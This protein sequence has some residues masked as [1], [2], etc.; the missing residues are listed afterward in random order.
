MKIVFLGSSDFSVLSLKR[1]IENGHKILAVVCQP[2]K[3]KGR[4]NKV[5]FSSVK[6]LAIENNIPVYQFQKIRAEGVE[7]LKDLQPELL[8]VVSYGQILSQEIIDIGSKGIINIHASLLPK[9]RGASPIITAVLNGE[10]K[11]G[12]TIMRVVKAVDAGNML[13]KAELE[14]DENETGGELADRLSRLGADLL[15][16]AIKKMESNEMV[17]EEQNENQATFTKMI[18]KEDA[19]L[20]FSKSAW[21]LKNQ[22]RAFNPTPIAFF[23]YGEEKIKV[24]ECEVVK[25]T[26]GIPGEI[27]KSSI[28]EGLVIK[29]GENAISIKKLQSPNGKVLDIKNFLNGRSFNLGLIK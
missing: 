24:Y 4:G 20:D 9:Y 2:D 1:L 26:E 29:C 3:P 19:K 23:K 11:T 21:E 13:M 17:E 28:K 10:R 6:K 5:E 14:I 22:V 8:V 18:Q 7:I 16:T 12:V 27:V 25:I 15:I